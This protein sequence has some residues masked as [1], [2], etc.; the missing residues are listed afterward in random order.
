MMMMFKVMKLLYSAVFC[1]CLVVV[2]LSSFSN[3]TKCLFLVEAKSVHSAKNLFS[4]VIS[5]PTTHQSRQ[6]KKNKLARP[7]VFLNDDGDEGA[8]GNR[9]LRPTISDFNQR[10]SRIGFVRKV[11]SIFGG[12]ILSTMVILFTIMN[13]QERFGRR[14]ELVYFLLRN[15]RNLAIGLPLG[16]LVSSMLLL[17]ND[18]IRHTFPWNVALLM[19]TTGCQSTLMGLFAVV[20]GLNIRKV[21]LSC[22]FSLLAL[23]TVTAYTFLPTITPT[24]NNKGDP[25]AKKN[26]FYDLNFIGNTLLALSSCVLCG[27]LLIRWFGLNGELE[28]L[29]YLTMLGSVVLFNGYIFYD[30]QLIIGNRK[31]AKRNIFNRNRSKS[32]SFGYDVNKKTGEIIQYNSKEYILA[33][34]N[35]YLDFVN[36]AFE[37][38]KIFVKLQSN[39]SKQREEDDFK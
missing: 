16:S 8:E 17:L 23:L 10:D 2:T 15:Q 37:I 32:T 33:A 27:R 13:S 12:Q 3:Q 11:Y 1:L 4:P 24:R 31:Q 5:P 25:F 14:S 18:K 26:N 29:E 6:I 36:L 7:S 20:Y 35:L 22:G 28:P 9:S 21:L 34:L 38:M 19:I 39:Q 30:T